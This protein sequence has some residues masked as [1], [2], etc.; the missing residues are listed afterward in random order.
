LIFYAFPIA[1]FSTF[2]YETYKARIEIELC[3]LGVN[4]LNSTKLPLWLGWW[5]ISKLPI[6]AWLGLRF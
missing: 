2:Q 3:S 1:V 6:R 5:G 4:I